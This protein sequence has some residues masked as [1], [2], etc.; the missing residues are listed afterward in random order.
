MTLDL[1]YPKAHDKYRE[2]D[3][4]KQSSHDGSQQKFVFLK[5]IRFFKIKHTRRALTNACA[6][7]VHPML[8]QQ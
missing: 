6:S 2:T 3:D 8:R 1:Q 7:I 5:L 4:R